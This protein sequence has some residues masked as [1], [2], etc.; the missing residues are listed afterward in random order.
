MATT[1]QV[2]AP[3]RA[4]TPIALWHLLSLDAPTVAALWTWFIARACRIHLPIVAPIGMFVAVW[5]LYAADRLLDTR[6]LDAAYDR[7]FVPDELEER[8][9]FHHGHRRAF[10]TGIA[11]AT[12]ALAALLPHLNAEAIHL[13]LVEGALLIGWFLLL[14]SS[15]DARHLPKELAVGVFFAPA[16]FI[17][18]IARQ[19]GSSF[20]LIPSAILLAA[21]CTLNCLFIHAWEDNLPAGRSPWRHLQLLAVLLVIASVACFL[22]PF[23][24]VWP[25][26]AACGIAAFC[27][28]TL[29]L[30]RRHLSRI[31]LRAAAD[32]ALLTPLLLLP[33][34]R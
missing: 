33:F 3:A 23:D 9:L 2:A 12:A 32:L 16:V 7:R 15:S 21:L 8:H 19:P 22:L 28:L 18:T 11:L 13:Y 24:T 30:T 1:T 34:L 31:H 4:H 10:R 20:A 17:P 29:H 6:R 14:H 5:I 27:L 25:L 26:Q